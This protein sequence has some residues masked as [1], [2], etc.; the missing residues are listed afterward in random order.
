MKPEHVNCSSATTV[1]EGNKIRKSPTAV[2]HPRFDKRS[3]IW[4][5]RIRI[6]LI[7][8]CVDKLRD[9]GWKLSKARVFML[10]CLDRKAARLSCDYRLHIGKQSWLIPAQRP[11][12]T[13]TMAP[14]DKIDHNVIEGM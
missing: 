1:S 11:Y 14:V 4:H 8:Q 3:N 6:E 2:T 5:P 7:R 12:S 13:K 9:K 10:I